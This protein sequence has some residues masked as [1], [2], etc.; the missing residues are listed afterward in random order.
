[1]RAKIG[2][3]SAGMKFAATAKPTM[4]S[5]GIA[6]ACADAATPEPKWQLL[7][8]EGVRY[9]GA[10]GKLALSRPVLETMVRNFKAQGSRRP[11]N[12]F[13]KGPSNVAA[14]IDE[15]IAGGW[16]EDVRLAEK[17]LEVLIRYTE[18]ARGFIKADEIAYLS[19]E[20]DL[21]K[22]NSTTGKS[23]GPTLTGAA[24]LNDPFILE[25]VAIAASENTPT[26]EVPKMNLELLRKLFKLS[27]DATEETVQ[28][29]IVALAEGSVK[30]SESAEAATIKLTEANTRLASAEAK[31]VTLTAEVGK[32]NDAI[33]Q[34]SV[35]K[36]NGEVKAFCDALIKTGQITPATRV[37]FE[38]LGREKGVEAIK[39]LEKLPV[40]VQ[41][42]EKGVSGATGA[43]DKKDAASKR[44]MAKRAE[45]EAKGMSFME[46]HNTTKAE[47]AE[48]YAI[49]FSAV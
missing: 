11:V 25:A 39:F 45:F 18:R 13:H 43:E 6:I 48:D 10:Y 17:G 28:A 15:K 21:D 14:A 23:Q 1:M 19:A 3:E 35:E 30:F 36:R 24:L 49:A 34:V 12:Y 16:I 9:H 7:L 5:E 22:L 8:P 44:F 2:F 46:A 38:Q 29:A 26:Q 42:G 40:A 33:E 31:V 27:A 41:M 47:L 37:E 4:F 20:F 32:L